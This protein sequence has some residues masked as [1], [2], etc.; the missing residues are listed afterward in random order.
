M[1]SELGSI[2]TADVTHWKFDLKFSLLE[3]NDECLRCF[4]L[5]SKK[6]DPCEM[7]EVTYYNQYEFLVVKTGYG[8][9]TAKIN[10]EKFQWF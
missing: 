2:V 3:K 5:E 9:W 10:M 8:G 1:I 7:N 4:G 6:E